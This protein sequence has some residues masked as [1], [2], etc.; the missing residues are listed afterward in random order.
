MTDLSIRPALSTDIEKIQSIYA[1]YVENSLATF[2]E[3][4]PSLEEMKKRFDEIHTHKMPYLVAEYKGE[5]VGYAYASVFR[6]RPAFRYCVEHSIYLSNEHSGLGIG[7]RLM[8]RLIKTLENTTGIRQMI[9]VIGDI[10]NKASIA[11]HKKYGFKHTGVMPAT[12]YKFDQWV[13]TV[14]MQRA[15]NSGSDTAPKGQGLNLTLI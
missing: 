3:A 12:G 5:L 9:G 4:V 10:K 13:D 1:F 11:L 8:E 15:I 7:S 14:L 2:E 6:S